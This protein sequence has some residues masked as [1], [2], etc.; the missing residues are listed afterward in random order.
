MQRLCKYP[1]LLVELKK[2]CAAG[3]IEHAELSKI[4]EK[5]NRAIMHINAI[6]RESEMFQRLYE[7]ESAGV[8]GVPSAFFGS[9]RRLLREDQVTLVEGSKTKSVLCLMFTGYTLFVSSFPVFMYCLDCVLFIAPNKMRITS[10]AEYYAKLP[11]V[12]FSVTL[13]LNDVLDNQIEGLSHVVEFSFVPE[14]NE[15]V[16]VYVA[17]QTKEVKVEWVQTIRSICEKIV[18]VVARTKAP[19]PPENFVMNPLKA[20]SDKIRASMRLRAASTSVEEE[21]Q[22]I[23]PAAVDGAKKKHSRSKS[24]SL[25]KGMLGLGKDK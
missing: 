6:R 18:V 24:A 3:S 13:L 22:F 1:L 10:K 5:M 16:T 15:R 2:T 12:M 11:P 25:E 4:I 23:P 17:L 14:D 7:I 8:S 20:Q 19:P 9:E 21:P